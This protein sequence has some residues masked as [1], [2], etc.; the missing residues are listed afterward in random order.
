[1]SEPSENLFRSNLEKLIP[2][3]IDLRN[4]IATSLKAGEVSIAKDEVGKN[5]LIRNGI[6]YNDTHDAISESKKL[7]TNILNLTHVSSIGFF[8]IGAG[9]VL[10]ALKNSNKRIVVFDPDLEAL[11]IT[12]SLCSFNDL[13]LKITSTVSEFIQEGLDL[14]IVNDATKNLYPEHL[15]EL[16]SISEG[17]NQT[18][19]KKNHSKQKKQLKVLVQSRSNILSARGGDS[20]A[21]ERSCEALGKLGVE[22]KIDPFAQCNPKDY[23]LV[24]LY[25]FATPQALLPLA[26]QAIKKGTPYIVTTL[27]E[28]RPAFYDKMSIYGRAMEEYIDGI[29]SHLPFQ[30]IMEIIGRNID[31]YPDKGVLDNHFLAKHAACLLASGEGERQLLLRDYPEAKR[32]EIAHFGSQ[33]LPEVSSKLFEEKYGISNYVLCVARL[34]WRKNQAM[35]MKAMEDSEIPVV[36]VKGNITYQPD[37]QDRVPYFKRKG[38]NLTVSKLSLEELASAYKGALAHVLPSWYEL[39]G[40]VTL[41]AA[42][43][44]TPV[45][46]TKMGTLPDYLG[47]LAYYCEP[48][49]IN[50]III[51][52]NQAINTPK[53]SPHTRQLQTIAETYTWENTAKKILDAYLSVLELDRDQIALGT[54]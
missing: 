45:V 20:V 33:G 27:Y 36:L 46:A 2:L 25:N 6:S 21:L 31:T 35:L 28:D 8:G 17:L 4:N 5:I 40:L 47:D 50:S 26:E 51:A 43:C 49:D 11:G 1:M 32:I 16:N 22:M 38:R 23:D 37:Y 19:K 15:L 7:A 34:E 24:H 10:E 18:S 54:E 48:G 53:H 39:P 44:G 41:E 52:I 12:L 30:Q 13:N 9:Y 3:D 14:I 29:F 42:R